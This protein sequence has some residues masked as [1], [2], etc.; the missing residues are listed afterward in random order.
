MDFN[1]GQNW[2]PHQG[3][4]FHLQWPIRV[5]G[6]TDQPCKPC[7]Q[8]THQ[9][10][11]ALNYATYLKLLSLLARGTAYILRT[12]SRPYLNIA[13]PLPLSNPSTFSTQTDFLDPSS[14]HSAPFTH[15]Q[16]SKRTYWSHMYQLQLLS[17]TCCF[18]PILWFVINVVVGSAADLRSSKN[19]QRG[20]GTTEALKGHPRSSA[21][22]IHGA[23]FRSKRDCFAYI[24]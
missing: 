10:T 18:A 19:S 1:F 9:H 14:H 20:H 6:E 21:R 11:T 24:S 13:G 17:F 7:T 15:L 8:P 23:A 22:L 5:P 4:Q 16:H 12:F 3:D 2:S